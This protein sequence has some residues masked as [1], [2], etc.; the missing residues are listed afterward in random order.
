MMDWVPISTVVAIAAI[1]FAVL[2]WFETRKLRIQAEKQRLLLE[3]IAKSLP[4]IERPMRK[5]SS[6]TKSQGQSRMRH[7]LPNP[8][9]EDR[10][11]LKFELEREKLQWQKNKDIAKGLA[12]IV[13]RLSVPEDDY[14]DE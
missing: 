8:A 2:S 9:A 7:T 4:Y 14:G 12:W 6:A 1:V 11:R 10:K 13:G 3:K 5:N